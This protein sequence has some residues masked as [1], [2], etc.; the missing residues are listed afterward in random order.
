MHIVPCLGDRLVTVY[1]Y[2]L[3]EMH[4]QLL[5]ATMG[6]RVAIRN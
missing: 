5:I 1:S 2:G 4:I 6:E 3:V